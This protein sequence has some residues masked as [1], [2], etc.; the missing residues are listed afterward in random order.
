MANGVDLLWLP[1]GAGG[2]SVRLNGRVFE[3]VAAR[4]EH[5][6]RCDLYHSALEVRL[7]EERF[8]IEQAP[9]RPD[10][11][12]RGVVVEG[13][14]GARAA[15]RLRVFRYEVRRWRGGEIPDAAE[16][17]ASPQHVTDDP[18]LARRLLELVPDVPAPVW[19]RDELETGEMWNSNSVT[20][21]LLE[22]SGIGAE[23]VRLPPHGRAPGW[24]A[25]LVVARRK[26]APAR[27]A[28]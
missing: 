14:V 6:D 13:P 27:A 22:R 26:Q 11:P 10:G 28:A 19:G 3:A 20:S 17:V 18:V 4:L 16:A 1:L 9:S 23:A 15:G 2:R 7:P 25:G 8:V 12:E 5:R 21:W 24:H